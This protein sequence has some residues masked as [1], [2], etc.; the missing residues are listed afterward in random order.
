MHCETWN[1]TKETI[2]KCLVEE[3]T[4]IVSL[5]SAGLFEYGD[6]GNRRGD[7]EHEHEESFELDLSSTKPHENK[8]PCQKPSPYMIS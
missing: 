8:R 1:D 5:F 6:D 3:K 2:G 7:V 4:N